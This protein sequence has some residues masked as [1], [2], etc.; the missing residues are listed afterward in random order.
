MADSD[1]GPWTDFQSDD[2]ISDVRGKAYGPIVGEYHRDAMYG[3]KGNALGEKDVALSPDLQ[4]KFP[5]GSK[6]LA[7]GQGPYTV[8]D[9]SYLTKGYP[10]KNT[11][12]FRDTNT[13]PSRVTLTPDD[14][15]A[16]EFE[17]NT[18]PW[19][20]FKTT[21]PDNIQSKQAIPIAGMH[22]PSP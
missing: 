2:T 19:E 8:A 22:A 17:D 9:V 7:N 3:P 21:P 20:D 1:D 10:N 4:K 15:P 13:P 18:P 11:I 6:V 12:E 5:H 14:H 16:D